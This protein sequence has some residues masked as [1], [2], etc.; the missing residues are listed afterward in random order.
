[1]PA[2]FFH[3]IKG[4]ICPCIHTTR[5]K[6]VPLVGNQ[7]LRFQVDLGIPSSEFICGA[8]VS[9]CCFPIQQTRFRQHK[10]ARAYGCDM[11]APAIMLFQPINHLALI[12]HC[13]G[14]VQDGR[15]NDEIRGGHVVD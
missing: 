9:G 1:M 5:A 7:P 13:F 6:Q 11:G 4:E 10:G 8:P 14:N 12:L 15:D 2:V 3:Q